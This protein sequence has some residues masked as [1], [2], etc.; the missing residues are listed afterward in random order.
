MTDQLA[1]LPPNRH[2]MV[3]NGNFTF[4]LLELFAELPLT[5]NEKKTSICTG[6]SV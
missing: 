5:K 1:D 3:K 6:K 4:L 2:L